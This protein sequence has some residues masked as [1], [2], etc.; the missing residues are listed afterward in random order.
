M[1]CT[2]YSSCQVLYCWWHVLRAI[3]MRF[4]INEFLELWTLIQNW[5]CTTD[6]AK[7]D[8]WWEQMRSNKSYPDTVIGYLSHDWVSCKD[9][10]C[11]Q[12]SFGKIDIFS[13]RGTLICC[14]N[15]KL[16][17]APKPLQYLAIFNWAQCSA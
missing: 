9:T 8:A 14:W 6:E 11:E 16:Q 5:V 12:L 17:W 13:K 1:I 7:F 2:T 3:W 15:C 4:K 10:V